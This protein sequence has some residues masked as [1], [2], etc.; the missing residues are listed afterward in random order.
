[1]K[2][3][4]VFCFARA[5]SSRMRRG[6]TLIEVLM[7]TAL[8][9]LLMV[10]VVEMFAA[11]GD[12][13]NASRSILELSARLRTVQSRMQMDL[14]GMT[15]TMLPPRP[16]EGNEGYAEF[17][18]GPT[19]T[20]HESRLAFAARLNDMTVNDN[21]DILMFTT[22]SKGRPFVGRV[23]GIAQESDVAEVAWFVR[24]TTLYR[25][26][27][28]VAPRFGQF[29]GSRQAGFYRDNDL[30]VHFDGTNLIPN[31][32]ADLT[33]RECRF[34]HCYAG[35]ATTED[36]RAGDPHATAGW[37]MLGLPTLRECSADGSSSRN[38]WMACAPLPP[39]ASTMTVDHWEN[40]PVNC[41]E[42]DQNTD[43]LV[44][45]VGPRVAEDVILTNVIGFDI[46]VW[47]PGAPVISNATLAIGPGDEGFDAVTQPSPV[48]SYGAYVDLGYWPGYSPAQ[49]APQPQFHHNGAAKSGLAS[50]G[51]RVYDTWSTHY[52]H[53]GI[54]QHGDGEVDLATDGF[55]NNNNG[56][57]DDVGNLGEHETTPP[58]P[59]PL[60]GIRVKIRAFDPD[61]RQ[62]RE[63]TVVQDFLPK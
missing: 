3:P 54:D 46:Q 44:D 8:T 52:E 23:N 6:F 17:R 14:E 42:L 62:I 59:A 51:E 36:I 37:A 5:R 49:G 56:I 11:V 27:L 47:D 20:S 38:A 48:A 55:D 7:A 13:V 22:R 9:A 61:S 19:G 58:Y 31:T 26:V 24:G 32:L 60:R 16:P 1:M 35:D 57:V 4:V 28:L 45:Y 2:R 41:P 18:E 43:A 34:A 29:P 33:R 10:G 50:T 40:I 30:S 53:D 63:V 39:G 15:V 25:R 12:S 21:D